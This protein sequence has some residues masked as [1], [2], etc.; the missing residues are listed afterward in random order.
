MNADGSGQ[1]D[2]TNTKE[3]VINFEPAWSP[4]GSKVVFMR[5][6]L[7]PSEQDIW[8]VNANGTEPV[9]LTKSP[10]VNETSP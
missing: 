4:D 9:D 1:V 10:G 5:Q 2:L 8:T 7:T 6:G 3:P